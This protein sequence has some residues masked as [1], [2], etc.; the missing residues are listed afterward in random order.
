MK[1][2]GLT[3]GIASGKSAVAEELS[4]LG[5]VVL[6]ADQAAHRV[7]DLPAVQAELVDRWGEDILS[8]DGRAQRAKVAAIVFANGES[9]SQEL[10][11]LEQTLHPRIRKEFEARLSELAKQNTSFAVIDAPLLLE[12]GWGSL[13]DHLIFVDSPRADRLSRAIQRNW[14]ETEL[15]KREA[16]QM[17]IAEKRQ[18]STHILKNPGSLGD[19]HEQVSALWQ[20]LGGD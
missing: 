6:D 15:A 12:A 5:A 10:Q 16:C 1:V 20:A 17:P 9:A 4:K 18:Q 8:D 19:L 13:C 3:G 2:I 11:F 7:L 14:T